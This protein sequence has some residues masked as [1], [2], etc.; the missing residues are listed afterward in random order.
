MRVADAA[1][2][3]VTCDAVWSVYTVQRKYSCSGRIQKND[4]T[5]ETTF[6]QLNSEQV[7]VVLEQRSRRT[8]RPSPSRTST[9]AR[10]GPPPP[11]RPHQLQ[12]RQRPPSDLSRE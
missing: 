3:S 11:T 9:P 6:R 2:C 10:A 8:A 12:P 5:G 7:L 4:E 1:H